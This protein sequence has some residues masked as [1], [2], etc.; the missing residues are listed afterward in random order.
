M[1]PAQV[2]EKKLIRP[3]DETLKLALDGKKIVARKLLD[4]G[5]GRTMNGRP[6][7]IE[8]R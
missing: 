2:G 4:Q 5:Y 1:L 8:W 6:A 7:A 3:S